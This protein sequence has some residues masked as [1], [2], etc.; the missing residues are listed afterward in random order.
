MSVFKLR[1]ATVKINGIVPYDDNEL[2]GDKQYALYT[3]T[4]PECHFEFKISQIE[5]NSPNTCY[6]K[7]YGVSQD[8]YKLFETKQFA[9]MSQQQM[10]EIYCGY[11]GDEELVYSGTISRVRYHFDFG[12]QYMEILLDQNIK[13]AKEQKH[14]LCIQRNTTLYEA[15]NIV[16]KRFG[17]K[18]ICN[19]QG[20]FEAIN[21]LPVTLE[22]NIRD[23]LS[24]L[25]NKKMS[26]YIDMNNIII[27]SSNKQIK[28]EYKLLFENG[29]IGYPTLDTGKLDEG[30][31]YT[32]KH[33]LIPSLRVGSVI[34]IP[35]GDDGL[36]SSVDTGKYVK[37]KVEEFVSTFS[38]SKDMTEMECVKIDG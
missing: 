7:I 36:F 35:V 15:L 28:K 19:N 14:S 5:S 33:K 23:C 13:K 20:D 38:T 29:L 1:T 37:Y 30:E 2:K 21:I 17:Y 12:S 24:M 6:L 27:Y 22:G 8:T 16:C 11:D 3:F 4:Y 10:V 31:K 25:L 9:T 26:Y 32:I 18:L 34:N